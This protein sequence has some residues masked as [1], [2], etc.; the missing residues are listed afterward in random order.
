MSTLG[1]SL[2]SLISTRTSTDE[3]DPVFDLTH[4]VM[5]QTDRWN[6]ADVPAKVDKLIQQHGSAESA[7]AALEHEA[8]PEASGRS[9]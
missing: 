8:A 5:R 9:E 3:P 7:L 6:L 4:E 2:L 1:R